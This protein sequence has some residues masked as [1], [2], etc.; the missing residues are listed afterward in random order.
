[1]KEITVNLWLRVEN[2]NKFVRGKTRVRREI[3]NYILSEYNMNKLCRDGWEYE[4][5]IP[6]ETEKDLDDTVYDMLMEMDQAADLRNCFIEADV[7]TI[8]GERSW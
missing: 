3:E 8:N 7:R 6:Y 1:M 2:N 4:L 5:T